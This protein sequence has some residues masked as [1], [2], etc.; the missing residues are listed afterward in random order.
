M[1]ITLF[2]LAIVT[3][4]CASGPVRF[5]A[6]E[7]AN[8]ISPNPCYQQRGKPYQK[9]CGFRLREEKIEK[10]KSCEAGSSPE[11]TEGQSFQ[12]LEAFLTAKGISCDKSGGSV[13]N[14]PAN[15]SPT[16]S[17]PPSQPAQQ[18]VN[19]RAVSPPEI[20][21]ANYYASVAAEDI[22]DTKLRN[23]L[24][25]LTA[26]AHQQKEE[27]SG[28]ELLLA[29]PKPVPEKCFGP[30]VFTYRQ[31]RMIIFTDLWLNST[32]SEK[33]VK[34]IY[35]QKD[36]PV[37]GSAIPSER[38]I[39]TE[40]SWPQSK[41][42]PEHSKEGQKTDLHHLFPSESVHN[43]ERSNYYFAEINLELPHKKLSCHTD[44]VHNILGTPI[45]PDGLVLGTKQ[46]YFEPPQQ[47]RGDIARAL[48]YFSIRYQLPIDDV[49]EFYL[50]KWHKEDAVSPEEKARHE[51]VFYWQGNRN[52][53]IDVPEL[54]EK[55]A[56]F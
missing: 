39:N 43:R 51:R 46:K 19:L 47:I 4:S 24:H 36:F 49:E 23:Q 54:A 55:I 6:S 53:F 12:T 22:K 45:V 35:C 20:S 41:F 31:A 10:F 29:C 15:P 21:L 42:N 26:W 48:M 40:H 16:K 13:K 8:A 52:P 32:G 18:E 3:L 27:K 38:E 50:K 34:D 56:N 25:L 17:P 30:K 11:G 2:I 33:T 44:E 7:E 14:P 37:T 5:L 1:K 28:D 9:Y